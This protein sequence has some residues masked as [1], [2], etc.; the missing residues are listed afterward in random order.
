MSA[1]Q[2]KKF[3]PK[4]GL[5]LLIAFKQSINIL[6]IIIES[7][8][9]DPNTS[10]DTLRELAKVLYDCYLK[11]MEAKTE[12]DE[13]FYIFFLNF[14]LDADWR[15]AKLMSFKMAVEKKV[16]EIA[17]FVNHIIEPISSIHRI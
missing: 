9:K 2:L 8:E 7:I 13:D 14:F 4:D 6:Y 10:V 3:R 12:C 15:Q 17:N 1:E 16:D 5:S 11:A